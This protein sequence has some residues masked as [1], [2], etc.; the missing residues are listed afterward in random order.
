MSTAVFTAL[1][2]PQA[3]HLQKLLPPIFYATFSNQHAG[4]KVKSQSRTRQCQHEV[5]KLYGYQMSKPTSRQTP[6]NTSVNDVP[7]S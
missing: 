3:D 2:P 7:R 4:D 1:V 6:S 5:D